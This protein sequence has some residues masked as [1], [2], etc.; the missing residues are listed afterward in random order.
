[1]AL[2][3]TLDLLAPGVR[4]TWLSIPV[5]PF[6]PEAG[7]AR[8]KVTEL[9]KKKWDELWA[10]LQQA[11]RGEAETFKNKAT[12]TEI[13]NTKAAVREAQHAI[14]KACVVSHDE[15]DFKI[16]VP[17]TEPEHHTYPGLMAELL[18]A[19]LHEEAAIAAL[20]NGFAFTPF[21]SDKGGLSDITLE[22][23]ER[24]SPDRA[25]VSMLLTSIQ[26]FQ[27]TET[28]SAAHFWRLA[29]VPEERIPDFFE[30]QKQKTE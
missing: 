17:I 21:V 4:T 3:I 1:M 23:Y 28:L 6:Q 27:A 9:P 7:W 8:V 29:K 10:T 26:R 16:D 25:F 30:K 11:E 22:L 2:K 12:P 5:N 13:S 18:K 19:G 24:L 15:T 14:L 20:H